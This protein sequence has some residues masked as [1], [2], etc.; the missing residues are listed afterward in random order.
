V[1]IGRQVRAIRFYF[2]FVIVTDF[3][4]SASLPLS[5][6]T[7]LNETFAVRFVAVNGCGLVTTKLKVAPALGSRLVWFWPITHFVDCPMSLP[8]KRDAEHHYSKGS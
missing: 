4:T 6:M 8:C 3:V 2:E 5:S 7:R 1:I